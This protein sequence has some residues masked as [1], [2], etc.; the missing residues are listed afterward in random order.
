MKALFV[1]LAS[2]ALFF[3]SARPA[4]AQFVFSF[5]GGPYYPS[6][7][8]YYSDY[9]GYYP[10]YYPSYYGYGWAATIGLGGGTGI[11]AGIMA[12]GA[13]TAGAAEVGGMAADAA[14][15]AADGAGMVTIDLKSKSPGVSFM[16]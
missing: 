16:T 4:A 9:Y 7:G 14:G 11:T 8:G 13:G 15:M 3:G 5:G 2:C 12:G 1:L 10:G 6:Y